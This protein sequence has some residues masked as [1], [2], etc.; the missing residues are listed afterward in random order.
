VTSRVQVF[1]TPTTGVAP[2][3]GARQPGELWLNF[4]DFQLGM[5]DASKTAQK[6]MAVRYFQTTANYAVGDFVI[7]AGSLYVANTAITAGAFSALQ[8]NRITTVADLPSAY[9]LPTASTTVLGGVKI[10]G[11]S[12]TIASGVISAPGVAASSTTPL[13]DG[14]AAAGTGAT[15]ARADH[16]HPSDTSRL[17][18][19]GVVNGSN[20]A[21]GAIGEVISSNVVSPGVTLSSG[22]DVN[23]T[24]ILLTAGDWDVA[25]EAW[26]A[27]SATASAAYAALSPASATLPVNPALNASNAQIVAANL[28][29]ATMALKPCRASLSATTTYYL[30]AAAYFASGTGNAY[31]NIIARR[32]R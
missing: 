19:L 10:D 25:G 30:V 29:G 23:V 16:V 22:V 6:L 15:Y 31:G 7:Q 18:V 21:A 20:A 4:A 8:W 14:A 3:A 13:M 2:A 1:R 26:V 11:S 5:I 9:V 12:I 27:L 28:G 17:P 24:S 32:R